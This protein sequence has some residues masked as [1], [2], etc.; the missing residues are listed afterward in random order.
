MTRIEE[1]KEIVDKAQYLINEIKKLREF[2]EVE[3]EKTL[4]DLFLD[5][6]IKNPFLVH[7]I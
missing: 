1:L 3:E 5:Y 2:E 4:E 6:R 7:K